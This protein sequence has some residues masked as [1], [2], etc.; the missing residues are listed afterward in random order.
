MR[1]ILLLSLLVGTAAFAQSTTIRGKDSSGNLK[2]VKVT[3][4][5]EVISPASAVKLN[6]AVSFDFT[7]SQAGTTGSL[8]LTAGKYWVSTFIENPT[9]C[10]A[11]TCASGGR[12]LQTGLTFIWEIT[13]S[14][15][16]SCRSAAGTG[17]IQFTGISP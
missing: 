10:F 14:Q 4:T 11:S 7:C 12:Q 5:G 13:T 3:P 2:D 15:V 17:L 6:P 1:N 9:Y 8:T 16:F